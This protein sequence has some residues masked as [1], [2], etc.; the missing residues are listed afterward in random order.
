VL[1]VARLPLHA[2][3]DGRQPREVLLG[4]ALGCESGDVHLEQ[5][6]YLVHL[7]EVEGRTAEVEAHRLAD[8]G[9]VDR[10]HAQP[11]PRPDLDHALGDKRAHRLPHDGTGDVELLAELSLRREAVTDLELPREDRL[12]HHL[13]DLVGQARLPRH[14]LEERLCALSRLLTRTIGHARDNTSY[15]MPVSL[16]DWYAVV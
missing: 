6:P 14:L 12:E 10:G 5:R 7:L 11:A 3:V 9:G 13:R 4:G 15:G 2:L 16:D 8:G 1:D